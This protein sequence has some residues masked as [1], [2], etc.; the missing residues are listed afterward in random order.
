MNKMLTTVAAVCATLPLCADTMTWN[1]GSGDVNTAA[2]WS[3]AQVPTS[4][5]TANIKSGSASMSANFSAAALRI[6]SD[7]DNDVADFT[8]TAG[9][10]SVGSTDG[11]ILGA[12]GGSYGRY[13]M[14]G[15]SL[16]IPGGQP[17]IGGWGHGLIRM[18]GGTVAS[19]AT[20]PTLGHSANASVFSSGVIDVRGGTFEQSDTA[21]RFCIGEHGFGLLSV[22]GDGVFRSRIPLWIGDYDSAVGR[23][24]VKDGGLLEIS[25]TYPGGSSGEK[26]ALFSGGTLK[27]CGAT[28]VASGFFSGVSTKIGAGGMT[29]ETAGKSMTLAA[30]LTDAVGNLAQSNLVHRWSF[31]DGSLADSVGSIAARTVGSNTGSIS[32]ADD[33]ITLPGGAHNSARVVLGDGATTVLPDSSAGVTLEMWATLHSKTLNYDRVFSINKN[34]NDS[35]SDRFFSLCWTTSND[36]AD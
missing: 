23:V 3:P 28:D 19:S 32:T 30:P 2:N 9:T 31:N 13:F 26:T 22:G 33:Q 12:N 10:A 36:P 7:W 21:T 35:Q 14:K 24:V 11:L 16:S 25:G 17:Q 5:D 34:W 29:V 8:Q 15:G 4:A 20:W 1:G 27:P 18:T 6:A